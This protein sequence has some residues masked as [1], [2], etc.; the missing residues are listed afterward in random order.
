MVGAARFRKRE[1]RELRQPEKFKALNTLGEHD[2][3]SIK[4]LQIASGCS[5]HGVSLLNR[6]P[7][8][9]ALHRLRQVHTFPMIHP[10]SF[11]SPTLQPSH[12]RVARSL[13]KACLLGAA[14]IS[15]VA[16][17]AKAAAPLLRSDCSFGSDLSQAPCSTTSLLLAGDKILQFTDLGA[18]GNPTL[19]SGSLALIWNDLGAAGISPEDTYQLLTAFEPNVPNPTSGFYNTGFYSYN[20]T[21]NPAYV[22]DGY[23]FKDIEI[24][25]THSGG[26]P[27]VSK[28]ATGLIS[29]PLVSL[30]DAGVGPVP[31]AA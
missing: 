10:F 13:T 27:I 26:S 11:T 12:K 14:A 24:D 23:T 6:K 4:L 29:N 8:E 30:N 9:L 28:A 2:Y 5:N 22:A 17:S 7:G 20:L 19:P 3:A 21:I 15:L 25:I 18:L 31:L 1:R 16:G